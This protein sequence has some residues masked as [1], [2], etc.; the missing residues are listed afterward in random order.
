MNRRKFL[1]RLARA[2][3]AAAWVGSVKGSAA[4]GP[5][6][7]PLPAGPFPDTSSQARRLIIPTDKPDRFKLKVMEFNPV[8]APDPKDWELEVAGYVERPT[9]LRLEVFKRLP[10]VTQSSRL[11]CVQCWSARIT[12]NGFRAA[13][14]FRLIRPTSNGT[15]MRVDCADGYYDFHKIEDLLHPRTLFALGMFGEPLTPEHGAPLRLV[16]PFKYGYK[17][18]KLITKIT[19]TDHGGQGI[20]AD[21]WPSYYS[22]TGD[23]EPGY[24]HP[25]DYPGVTKK[26]NGGEVVEY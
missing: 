18:T 24:D 19:L 17:S 15:W 3:A 2:G 23:I 14:L 4:P 16:I 9:K 20:V 26:I 10:Q 6:C 13:E 5:P 7:P 12:W 1:N 8:L 11:K 21:A 22:P 25:F